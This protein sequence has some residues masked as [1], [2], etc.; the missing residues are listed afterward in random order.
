M[1]QSQ[2]EIRFP[3]K[4]PFKEMDK[5]LD[6]NTV[7]QMQVRTRNDAI[8]VDLPIEFKPR[9]LIPRIFT[10]PIKAVG[11]GISTTARLLGLRIV[12]GYNEETRKSK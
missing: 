10:T 12:I 2:E 5:L 7:R 11:V 3:T 6:G 1:S 8:L 4:R 9:D